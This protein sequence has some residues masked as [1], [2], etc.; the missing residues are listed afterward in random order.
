VYESQLDVPLVHAGKVRELYALDEDRLLMVAT[1]R[2]SAFDF[3][4][5]SQI[6]DKGR[7][8]TELSQW[9]FAQLVDLVPNHLL[10]TDVPAPV[11]GRA[12]VCERLEMVP[13]SAW[14]GATS[15][16]RLAGVPAVPHR[17]RPAAAGRP[18]RRLPAARAVFTPATKAPLG[19]HDENVD[20]ADVAPPSATRWPSASGI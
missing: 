16:A 9:W 19:D 20:F 15:P 7:V 3:V 8:L 5:D 12:V 4:L 6:P 14:R 13:W 18:G 17:L 10:A 1:D 11:R 2:I